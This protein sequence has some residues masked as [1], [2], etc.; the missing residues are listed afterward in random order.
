MYDGTSDLASFLVDV[1]DKVVP[2][3]SHLV[4]DVVL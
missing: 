1:E 2:E 4:S 3:Q